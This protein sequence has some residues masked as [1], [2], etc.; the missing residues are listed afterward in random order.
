MITIK[1]ILMEIDL[2]INT[3]SPS[4]LEFNKLSRNKLLD[5]EITINYLCC[6]Y[7]LEG[8]MKDLILIDGI[9][10]ARTDYNYDNKRLTNI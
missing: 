2:F 6:E 1:L 5:Y 7:C 4:L 8:N 10:S 3:N 9:E